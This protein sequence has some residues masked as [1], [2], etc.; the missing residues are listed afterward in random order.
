MTGRQSRPQPANPRQ[1]RTGLESEAAWEGYRRALGASGQENL[2]SK[3]LPYTYSLLRRMLFRETTDH[4][5]SLN[6]SGKIHM[7]YIPSLPVY[8]FAKKKTKEKK[9]R[10]ALVPFVGSFMRSSPVKKTR[11]TEEG[12]RQSSAL[13]MG[14]ISIVI[15]YGRLNCRPCVLVCNV[16]TNSHNDTGLA[17]GWQ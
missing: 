2:K 7:C 14:Y 15:D 5:P 8:L 12:I 1:V 3:V 13:A 6:R 4:S 16:V 17:R 11:Q 10:C 9:E